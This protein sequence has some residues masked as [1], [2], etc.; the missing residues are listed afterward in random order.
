LALGFLP[1]FS[2]ND[3]FDNFM[4]DSYENFDEGLPSIYFILDIVGVVLTV[5]PLG[6]MYLGY[7]VNNLIEEPV[8]D[9]FYPKDERKLQ[10]G[11]MD[12]MRCQTNFFKSDCSLVCKDGSI[13]LTKVT[14]QMMQGSD[15]N[16]NVLLVC[17]PVGD[18]QPG[19][20]FLRR[21]RKNRLS[22]MD[23]G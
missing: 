22:P 15:I 16:H 19:N 18:R 2:L 10:I 3:N 17:Q 1:I 13:I 4:N 6:A 14:A 5:N 23:S 8:F 11:L 9:L 12:C 20:R 7:T 21:K